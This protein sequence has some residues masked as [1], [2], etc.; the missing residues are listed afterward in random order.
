ML[1]TGAGKSFIYQLSGLLLP[2][3]TIVIDPIV[4]LM[5]DQVEGLNSY[6][7][8]KAISISAENKNLKNDI[9]LVSDGEFLFI[10]HS[11]ERLQTSQYRSALTS[12]SQL[13][14]VN[15]AVLDEAHC[16]SEWGHEFR[17]AYLNVSETLEKCAKIQKE[18]T[19]NSRSNRNSI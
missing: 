2:G 6:G 17:P 10:L 3:S 16:V 18:V 8:D 11:P 9:R 5:E 7:I 19:S 13:S 12:L 1:P 4:A 15:L 14:L